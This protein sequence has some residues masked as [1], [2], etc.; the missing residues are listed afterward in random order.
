MLKIFQNICLKIFQKNVKNYQKKF[1]KFQKN[2]SENY[3]KSISKKRRRRQK[4]NFSGFS[5]V[6]GNKFKT[7]SGP[8]PY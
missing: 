6:H 4:V 1:K 2:I 5:G 7:F 3:K 8:R